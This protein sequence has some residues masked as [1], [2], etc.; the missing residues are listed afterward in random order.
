MTP[1]QINQAIAE[2]VGWKMYCKE[3]IDGNWGTKDKWVTDPRGM[4]CLRL[5][6]PDY[7][8][9]LNAIHEVVCGLRRGPG[10]YQPGGIG[11]YIDALISV[12]GMDINETTR[13]LGLFTIIN[14][15]AAQRCEAY[16][17]SIGKWEEQPE[18]KGGPVTINEE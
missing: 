5:D 16:L 4:S 3:A 9:D 17:D 7:Y 15:T 1:E 11:C 8:H 13:D 12:L 18:F 2:S 6:V 10:T 14:A